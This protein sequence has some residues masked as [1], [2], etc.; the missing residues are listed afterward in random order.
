[1]NRMS[2]NI[3]KKNHIKYHPTLLYL[4]NGCEIKKMSHYLNIQTL[5]TSK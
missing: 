2:I 4:T 3:K 1:M 5:Q